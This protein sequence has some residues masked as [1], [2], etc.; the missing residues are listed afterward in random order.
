MLTR[1]LCCAA[2]RGDVKRI[3]SL[4]R[5][6]DCNV[7][8]P[9]S[10]QNGK[11]ALHFAAE[12]LKLESVKLLIKSG[13]AINN[14]DRHGFTALALASFALAREHEGVILAHGRKVLTVLLEEGSDPFVPDKYGNSLLHVLACRGDGPCLTMVFE[15]LKSMAIFGPF[16]TWPGWGYFTPLHFSVENSNFATAEALLK[17]SNRVSFREKVVN[18]VDAIGWTPLHW[19]AMRGDFKLIELLCT[20]GASPIIPDYVCRHN[21]YKH[22]CIYDLS[23]I[24]IYIIRVPY[25]ST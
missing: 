20:H 7:N 17:F 14:T 18:V 6:R 22:T 15:I 12:N 3:E 10:D 16:L 9:L 13:A 5:E 4:L 11:S 2:E 24:R 25:V 21:T 8:F 19:A 23:Y 1:A